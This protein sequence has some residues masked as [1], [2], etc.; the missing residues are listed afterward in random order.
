[1]CK[2]LENL[3]VEKP[4]EKHYRAWA[5]LLVWGLVGVYAYTAQILL[6]SKLS[7]IILVIAPLGLTVEPKFSYRYAFAVLICFLLGITLQTRTF[8][9][10]AWVFFGL[11]WIEVFVGKTSKLW[12]LLPFI[13]SPI[14][15]Y[16][17]SVWSFPLKIAISEA[18][19]IVFSQLGLTAAAEGNMVLFEGKQF[20]VDDAC[21]GL[22]LF[23]LAYLFS[24]ILLAFVEKKLQI[25]LSWKLLISIF[26]MVFVLNILANFVRIL[27]LVFF[28]I[29]PEDSLH[30]W[31]GIGAV[32]V[33]IVLPIGFFIKWF[34]RKM[35]LTISNSIQ[36]LPSLNKNLVMVAA[37]SIL[38]GV[39]PFF[40]QEKTNTI[41]QNTHLVLEIPNFKKQELPNDIVQYSNAEILIY[42]KF[43]KNFYSLEHS[44]LLCW[45]GSGYAFEQ[46]K[47]V[48]VHHK[49]IWMG[50]L[51]KDQQ[52][53]H[54]A[55][56][57]D[58]G[59]E[60]SIHLWDWRW[61]WLKTGTPYYLFNVT[62]SSQKE[63]MDFLE[64]KIQK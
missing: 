43:L 39:M 49:E 12:V 37:L 6:V 36:L 56:W 31:V 22:K 34:F 50:V 44:P 52:Q 26:I 14:F 54:T 3:I 62:A 28:Q 25:R 63:L 48:R 57:M 29:P 23:S 59:K 1:L 20:T 27:L 60:Q 45:K 38:V 11:L 42:Q 7:L 9:Y 19:A 4:I 21:M 18:T 2:K 61:Q 53:L 33:Y 24:W 41:A 32:I 16:I 13:A 51:K 30:D 15:D 17:F 64:K 10:F 47:K 40:F 46:V 55:W 5:I 35:P 58:N 8:F